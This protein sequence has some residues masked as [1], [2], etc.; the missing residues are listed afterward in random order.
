MANKVEEISDIFT[1][2]GVEKLKVGQILIFHK[3]GK[4]IDLKITKIANGRVWAKQVVT[5]REDELV[6][7]TGERRETISEHLKNS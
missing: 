1:P 5:F 4:R 7:T 3:D 6:V 2:E